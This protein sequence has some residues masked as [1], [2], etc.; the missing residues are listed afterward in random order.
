[1]GLIFHKMERKKIKY[2]NPSEYLRIS[3][4]KY[5]WLANSYAY[6]DVLNI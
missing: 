6:D 3:Q 4:K 2:Q 5:G 1:M